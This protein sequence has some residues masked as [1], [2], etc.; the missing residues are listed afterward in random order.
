MAQQVR[1]GAF[2]REAAFVEHEDL[3]GI[4]DDVR[5]SIIQ[6]WF[7]DHAALGDAWFK[8][9]QHGGHDLRQI[10]LF[11]WCLMFGQLNA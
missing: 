11:R 7:D 9:G 6:H 1:V 10:D 5:H 2:F 8:P 4:G 3:V